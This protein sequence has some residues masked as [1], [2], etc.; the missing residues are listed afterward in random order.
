MGNKLES[1][2]TEEQ[3][4]NAKNI[5]NIVNFGKIVSPSA[6]L[7]NSKIKDKWYGLKKMILKKMFS[8]FISKN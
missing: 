3:E 1:W 6:D 7:F 8:L 5:D 4:V 2:M